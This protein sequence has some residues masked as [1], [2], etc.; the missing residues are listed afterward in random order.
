MVNKLVIH[1]YDIFIDLNGFLRQT[2]NLIY[3]FFYT[4]FSLILKNNSQQNMVDHNIF[5][6]FQQCIR[7]HLIMTVNDTLYS[8]YCTIVRTINL[9]FL[10]IKSH[11][12]IFDSY[13]YSMY[14][15]VH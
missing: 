1:F 2:V 7:Q 10:L 9:D 5:A 15:D 13:D 12:W 6:A 8:T 3:L 14:I 4:S 11:A